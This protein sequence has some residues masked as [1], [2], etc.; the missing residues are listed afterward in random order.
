MEEEKKKLKED[1]KIKGAQG[2]I[3]KRKL[4]LGVAKNIDTNQ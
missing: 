4:E 2:E 3:A 1:K